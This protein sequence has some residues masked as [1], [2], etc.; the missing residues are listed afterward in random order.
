MML[1]YTGQLVDPL[2]LSPDDI[3]IED[4][5]HSLALQNRYGGHT[6]WPYSVAQHSILLARAVPKSLARAALMH[7][8]SEAYCSD[9]PHPIK[10]NVPQYNSIEIPIQTAIFAKYNIPWDHMEEVSY[11]DRAIC[12]DEMSQLMPDID[13]ELVKTHRRLGV[14]IKAMSWQDVEEW[15]LDMFYELFDET[16]PAFLGEA[17]A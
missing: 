15:Y 7:D 4:I 17:I 6:L 2:N 5:A 16:M 14:M 12:L 11:Y 1:T 13:Q 9:L 10:K 8:A 3:D